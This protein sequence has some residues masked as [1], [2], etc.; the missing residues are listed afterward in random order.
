MRVVARRWPQSTCGRRRQIKKHSRDPSCS[1]NFPHQ[2]PFCDEPPNDRTDQVKLPEGAA[3]EGGEG[4]QHSADLLADS[5]HLLLSVSF[6]RHVLH[7]V[8]HNLFHNQLQNFSKPIPLPD[9]CWNYIAWCLEDLACFSA[10]WVL[11]VNKVQ[12]VTS[13]HSLTLNHSYSWF[14]LCRFGRSSS[15]TCWRTRP[16]QSSDNRGQGVNFVKI[17]RIYRNSSLILHIKW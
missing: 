4:V 1:L 10:W 9:G 12:W 14:Y 5:P 7:S 15:Y 3:S 17:H 11:H 13:Q 6:Q 2:R 8:L 16:M